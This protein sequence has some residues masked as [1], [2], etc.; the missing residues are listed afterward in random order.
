MLLRAIAQLRGYR[1][2]SF[3]DL[4][5]RTTTTSRCRDVDSAPMV[6]TGCSSL[7]TQ[8]GKLE[9]RRRLDANRSPLAKTALV[10]AIDDHCHRLV[11]SGQ[12]ASGVQCE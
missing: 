4:S 2:R 6:G 9:L 1:S 10:D 12:A 8:K 11:C 3:L 7:F 5:P